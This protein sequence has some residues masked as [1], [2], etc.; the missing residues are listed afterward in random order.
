MANAY[1]LSSLFS[2]LRTVAVAKLV[3]KAD[4]ALT[5]NYTIGAYYY[6]DDDDV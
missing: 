5:V 3:F 2:L 6:C 1:R 4:F